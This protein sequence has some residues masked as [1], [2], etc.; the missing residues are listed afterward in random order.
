MENYFP[1]TIKTTF[2]ANIFRFFIVWCCYSLRS[3]TATALRMSACVCCF[4]FQHFC[5]TPQTI[6][7]QVIQ[8][9]MYLK[10]YSIVVVILVCGGEGEGQV[11]PP[12]IRL[13]VHRLSDCCLCCSV[14][15]NSNSRPSFI[16]FAANYFVVALFWEWNVCP[17]SVAAVGVFSRCLRMRLTLKNTF[18]ANNGCERTFL[19]NKTKTNNNLWD[20]LVRFP[21]IPESWDN[22]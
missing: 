14:V 19:H 7:Q 6:I 12:T 9:V 16:T 22:F 1:A 15:N 20:L 4:N 11:R 3:D 17:S 2:V 13:S 18:N 5:S 10:S 21:S 8:L